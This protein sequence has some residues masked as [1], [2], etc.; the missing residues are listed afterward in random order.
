MKSVFIVPVV[1]FALLTGSAMAQINPFQRSGFSL[2]PQDVEMLKA[3]A[4]QLYVGET[5]AVGDA[6]Q[7][8]N[9]D[10]GNAG[11]VKLVRIF[12]EGDLKCRR[13]Q[14]DIQAKGSADP[15]RYIIDRCKVPSGEWKIK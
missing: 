4:A 13:L 11:T 2:E 5:A 12:D 10:S 14:H 7:W 15:V 9:A 8:S 3:A 6:R 1:L